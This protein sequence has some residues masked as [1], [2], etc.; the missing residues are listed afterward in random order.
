MYTFDHRD[1][2]FD[3]LST[4]RRI[5]HRRQ[6]HHHTNSPVHHKHPIKRY[7]TLDTLY[8]THI[9]AFTTPHTH[10]L[11]VLVQMIVQVGGW[12]VVGEGLPVD[13]PLPSSAEVCLHL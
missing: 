6:Q 4:C 9:L 5:R 3:F 1:V 10:T 7:T 12:D 13:E 8:T 2:C 11:T